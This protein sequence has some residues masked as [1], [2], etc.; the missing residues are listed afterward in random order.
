MSYTA[1]AEMFGG[2]MD[3]APAVD[4]LL[5]RPTGIGGCR[6]YVLRP[7]A[8][9]LSFY[10]P[11]A[12]FCSK[13]SEPTLTVCNHGSHAL[14]IRT[15]LLGT[16]VATVAVGQAAK[17]WLLDNTTY[18]GEWHATVS[19]AAQGT[20][21]LA[22]REPCDLLISG[23]HRNLDLREYAI[24][25]G[26][27]EERAYAVTARLAND[28]IIG[29][30]STLIPAC[31]SGTW[32][33]GTTMRMFLSAGARIC[34]RGGNGGR[35]GS[36]GVDGGT[37]VDFGQPGGAG[38][39][40]LVVRL[41]C[42]LTSY[43]KIQAGGGGGAGGAA[44]QAGGNYPGGG[45]GGGAGFEPSSGGLSGMVSGQQWNG[46]N[47]RPGFPDVAG[48][49]GGTPAQNG[50]AGGG[51]GQAGANASAGVLGGAAGHAIRVLTGKTLT[52]IRAGTIDGAEVS[53]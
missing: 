1:Y 12:M 14:S 50:Q 45:G 13:G 40:A 17:V 43:G 44:T 31:D 24:D 23:V 33:T 48:Q 32:P 2:S 19:S 30:E 51:P 49:G 8:S 29:S 41:D 38:G 53:F 39:H 15:S 18:W 3:A 16:L 6:F 47:G 28:A 7:S 35:G 10:L 25:L 9:G 5:R 4:D 26:Y 36:P 34:G 22:D 11:F 21:L 27:A 46:G 20:A 42:A 52:K 37:G